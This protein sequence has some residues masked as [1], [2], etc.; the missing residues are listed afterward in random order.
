MDAKPVPDLGIVWEGVTQCRM[1]I[2]ELRGMMTMH[3]KDG[4]H[5][6]PP[7]ATAAGL[8]KTINTALFTALVSLASGLG[9]LVMELIRSHG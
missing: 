7:C 1:D 6:Q 8:Q 2:A 3:F 9:V 5:H 4:A